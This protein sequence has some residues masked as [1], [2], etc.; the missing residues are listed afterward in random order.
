MESTNNG[1]QDDGSRLGRLSKRLDEMDKQLDQEHN[2]QNL[3]DEACA[4]FLAFV[5]INKNWFS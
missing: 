3:N 5:L 2:P 4:H 1:E